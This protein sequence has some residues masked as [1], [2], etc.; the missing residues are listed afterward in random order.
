MPR[1][2]KIKHFDEEGKRICG[3]KLKT[4]S[5]Q[6]QRPPMKNGKCRMHGGKSTGP[7]NSAAYYL[8][9]VLEAPD[10]TRLKDALELENPMDLTGEI[11]F[12]RKL[13]V[14]MEQDPLYCFCTSCRRWV[15][16]VASCPHEEEMNEERINEGKPPQDHNVYPKNKD[17]SK[18]VQATK[19]L[20][21]IV[22]NHKEIQK[23]KEIHIRIEVLNLLVAKVIQAYEEAD[24]IAQPEKRR[25]VFVGRL[26]GLLLSQSTSG[27]V[28]QEY[29]SSS[30]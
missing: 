27:V 18:L 25:D 12:V 24:R 6:C 10:G 16:V 19:A 26:E 4:K 14:E 23:G 15:E 13:L 21:E 17:S 29:Q 5:G 2:K 7:K 8:K 9:Q 1:S 20:S 28:A 3:A 30:N 22:K 11:G